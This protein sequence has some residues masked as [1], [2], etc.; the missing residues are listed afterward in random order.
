MINFV[1]TFTHDFNLICK[2]SI[3]SFLKFL[4]LRKFVNIFTYAF[5]SICKSGILRFLKSLNL[6]DFV[7]IFTIWLWDFVNFS[8]ISYFMYSL[9]NDILYQC[10]CFHHGELDFFRKVIVDF[11]SIWI[12]IGFLCS[13]L[14]S[15]NNFFWAK[16]RDLRTHDANTNSTS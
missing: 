14:N 6:R 3:L 16:F 7:N 12:F 2:N 11:I 1:N 8:C 9:I 5:N 15:F 10:T 4:N 13:K